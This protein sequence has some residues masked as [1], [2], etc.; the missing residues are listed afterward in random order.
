MA[1]A[2]AHDSVARQYANGFQEVLSQGVPD[3][4]GSL[5]HG[6]GL[7]AVIVHCYLH[8]MARYPD[9]LIARKRGQQ[10]AAEA[11]RRARQVLAANWPLHSEGWAA[12]HGLD[13]WLRA[14]GHQRNPGTTAD[15]VT[16]CLFAVLRDGRMQL[17]LA[18]PWSSSFPDP[19]A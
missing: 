17:P 5:Q 6:W 11:A 3:L 10:E 2:A 8:L 7:E 12:W 4:L 19:M 13:A 16:A 1:L 14:V 18:Q 15:L 9:S